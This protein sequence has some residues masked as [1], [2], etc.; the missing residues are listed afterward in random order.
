MGG[1]RLMDFASVFENAKKER[2]SV[3]TEFEAKEL[4]KHA[5]IPTV[6]TGLAKTKKQAASLSREIGYPVVLKIASPDVVHKSDS[7]GVILGLK[8]AAQVKKAYDEIM[9]RTRKH[10]PD[11]V[12]HGVTVQKMV[13]PGTE[14]IV[15]TTKDPQFGPVIMFGLGGV[16]VEVLKDVSF[17]IVPVSRTDA[18]EMIEEIKGFP[19]LQGYRGKEPADIRA[20]TEMILKISQW[21]EKADRIKELELNPVFAYKEGAVAVDARVILEV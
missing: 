18:R 1:R 21:I 13:P 14:V 2:R 5:G 3:L 17:R 8:T 11:A 9:D 15:G 12:I 16:F 4:I 6:E 19:L 7:G 20:L 10:Y